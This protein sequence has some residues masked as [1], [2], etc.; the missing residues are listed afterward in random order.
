M[1]MTQEKETN[2]HRDSD[3][4]GGWAMLNGS[5][6]DEDEAGEWEEEDPA[7]TNAGPNKMWHCPMYNL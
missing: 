3:G 6:G 5:G 4:D 2:G 1:N 7:E